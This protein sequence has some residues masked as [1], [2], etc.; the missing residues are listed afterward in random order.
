MTPSTDHPG[1]AAARPPQTA[2]LELFSVYLGTRLNLS[3][4]LSEQCPMT[5]DEWLR[6]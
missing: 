2:T 4:V 5:G 1:R 6:P 3:A